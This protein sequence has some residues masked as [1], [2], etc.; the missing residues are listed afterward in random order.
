MVVINLCETE[1]ARGGAKRRPL[2]GLLQ[3][4][5]HRCGKASPALSTPLGGAKD[6]HK[7]L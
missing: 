2:A 7:T 3:P 1:A 6:R 5:S 4:H